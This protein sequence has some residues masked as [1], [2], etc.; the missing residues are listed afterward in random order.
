MEPQEIVAVVRE[1][2]ERRNL[3][4][5]R[6]ARIAG[7]PENAV[8]T[9]L[10]GHE[11]RIGRLAAICRLLELELYVGPRREA[12]LGDP[13]AAQRLQMQWGSTEIPV[14]RWG[15]CSDVGVLSQAEE[16]KV[17]PAPA[18]LVD[19]AAFYAQMKGWS[20]APEWIS[21]GH[22]CLISPSAPLDAGQ[23]VWLRNSRNQ[24]VIRRLV[25]V[26]V[27]AYSLR[28][29]RPPDTLRDGQQDPVND[30]WL[31]TDIAAKGVVLVV[32]ARSPALTPEPF[33]VPDVTP[34]AAERSR[35]VLTPSGELAGLLTA[36]VKHY[37]A[38]NEYGRMQFL[39]DLKHHFP[40]LAGREDLPR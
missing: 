4:P 16:R 30:R 13:P 9:V 32:Y 20:M 23:R 24:E 12:E 10:D 11:P 34:A 29:W 1:E 26:D 25:A 2:L 37:E 17:A 22:Y 6:A 3:T 38:L 36:A 33:K 40:G 31:R 21:S 7:L 15:H 39:G 8:R 14:R 28:G 18:G 27:E 5:F 19:S 35:L